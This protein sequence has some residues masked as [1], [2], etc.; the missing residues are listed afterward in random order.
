[1]SK[2]QR[3]HFRLNSGSLLRH[4]ALLGKSKITEFLPGVR[5]G[6]GAFP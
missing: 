3:A 2:K 4:I 1:M 5:D 6:T